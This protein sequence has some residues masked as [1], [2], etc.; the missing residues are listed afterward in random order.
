MKKVKVKS[1]EEVSI[2]NGSNVFKC[3]ECDEKLT[4]IWFDFHSR[5]IKTFRCRWCKTSWS[6]EEGYYEL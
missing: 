6:Q 5:R 4:T 1:L 3:K 2:K